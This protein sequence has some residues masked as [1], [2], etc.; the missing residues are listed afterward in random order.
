VTRDVTGDATSAREV[1][2]NDMS[3]RSG[4]VVTTRGGTFVTSTS[5]GSRYGHTVRKEKVERARGK[6]ATRDGD[7]RRGGS[8]V[9]FIFVSSSACAT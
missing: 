3:K 7:G 4:R 8:E 1:S 9:C 6:N 2:A 5:S